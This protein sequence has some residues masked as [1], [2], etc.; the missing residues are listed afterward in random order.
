MLGPWKCLLSPQ[1]R[2]PDAQSTK[3]LQELVTQIASALCG[4][5]GK[6]SSD[7]MLA[8]WI[9]ALL[10]AFPMLSEEEVLTGLRQIMGFRTNAEEIPPDAVELVQEAIEVVESCNDFFSLGNQRMSASDGSLDTSSDEEM[11]WNAMTVTQLREHLKAENLP[12]A[13]RK[14]ELIARLED[15]RAAQQPSDTSAS[16]P[17][18]RGKCS[19]LMLDEQLQSMC[20]ESMPTMRRVAAF[21]MPGLSLLEELLSRRHSARALSVERAWYVVDPENN[22]PNTR[23]TMGE[24][25][26]PYASKWNWTGFIAEA[27]SKEVV[28]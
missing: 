25:I 23:K 12:T 22:L 3:R 16:T 8:E 24:F 27:P 14:A 10:L 26:D 1:D 5:T 4:G 19:I 7:D 17:S 6:R 15:H 13:G 28:Q 18:N 2:L 11:D 9:T 20:L 21:R